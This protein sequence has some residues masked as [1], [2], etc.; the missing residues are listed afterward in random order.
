MTSK[1]P[2]APQGSLE[3]LFKE[4]P[5]SA[6]DTNKVAKES[7]SGYLR[8]GILVSSKHAK[9]NCEH[10]SNFPRSVGELSLHPYHIQCLDNTNSL[11]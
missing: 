9:T 4:Y 3:Y 11:I 2:G 7:V 10:R 5:R 8:T 1:I 6:P